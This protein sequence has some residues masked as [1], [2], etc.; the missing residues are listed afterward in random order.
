MTTPSSHDWLTLHR[1]QF[2]ERVSALEHV[3]P[4]VAGADCWRFS[5]HYDIGPDGLPTGVSDVWGGVG[6]WR[7][8]EA[9]E[10]MLDAPEAAMPWLDSA[11]TSWHALCLPISHRGEVNRRGQVETNSAVRAAFRSGFDGRDGYT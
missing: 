6:I 3:F 5:P 9:A 4:P 11:V 8:R 10:A 1:V 7:D 2:A